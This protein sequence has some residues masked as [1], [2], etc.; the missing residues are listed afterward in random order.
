[1]EGS[2]ERP[3]EAADDGRIIEGSLV[4]FEKMRIPGEGYN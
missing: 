2:R 4:K 3:R 1:M